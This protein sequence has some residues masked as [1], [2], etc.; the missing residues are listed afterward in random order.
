MK[1]KYL[2]EVTDK[3]INDYPKKEIILAD[4]FNLSDGKQDIV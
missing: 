3:N 4:L 2:H 1:E